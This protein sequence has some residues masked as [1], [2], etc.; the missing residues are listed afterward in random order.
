MNY[1]IDLTA[2]MASRPWDATTV[3]S[4][5]AEDAGAGLAL[6]RDAL[7]RM[8]LPSAPASSAACE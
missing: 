4:L 3:N 1:A 2:R 8:K 7:Q 5:R 6:A